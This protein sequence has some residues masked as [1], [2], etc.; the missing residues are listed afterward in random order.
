M[1]YFFYML[2]RLFL[3]CA[4]AIL[5]AVIFA[6]APETKDKSAEAARLNNI[7]AAYMNQQLFDK[8]LKSFT[9]A[10]ELDPKLS[11]ANIN[12]GI[13]LVNI[14]KADE[15]RK[16]LEEAAKAN[17][18]DPHVWYNLGLLYKNNSDSQ[19][20]VDAFRKVTEIDPT[21]AD[22]WYFLG[23]AH[24][25]LKQ[26]P[27][28]IDAFQHALKLSP[29]HASAEFGLSRAYQQSGDATTAR[30]HLKRFQYITQNKLGS[31]ITLAYGEQGQ[32]SRVEESPG[33]EEKV[34][35]QIPVRFVD[36]TKAAGNRCPTGKA[37]D[38]RGRSTLIII[39]P[40]ACFLDYDGDG[41]I[42]LFRCGQRH[43]GRMSLYHNLG[44]GKFEDVA[45]KAG[46]D[47]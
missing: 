30:E 16:I 24:A 20:A 13:A 45:K 14:G 29:Q 9:E 47:R 42:D 27:Q 7:G 39:G 8:G 12:K 41:N 36:V 31:A 2:R 25:Q 32:Y 37:A 5:L 1:V 17:P 38:G 19:A 46:L 43:R 3:V 35:P 33:V 26:F 11:I 6:A 18:K 10:A 40:G 4:G 15:A 44:D 28:A 22:A 21:D 23:T 34:L